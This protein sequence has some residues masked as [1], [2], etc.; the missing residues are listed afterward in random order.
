MTPRTTPALR[1]HR[2]PR[3]MH[4]I[5]RPTAL[6][7]AVVLAGCASPPPP[8][9]PLRLRVIGFND[10]HGNLET[11][12]QTLTLPDPARPGATLRVAAGGAAPMAGLVEA[13]RAGAPHSLVVS[14]GD[15]IGAAPL[16]STLFRHE[17]TIEVMNRI[18]VDVAAVGNHE[19]DAGV[20]ELR[21]MAAGG[22]TPDNPAQ[23]GSACALTPFP[24]A[25][26]TLLAAN[27][28][29]AEGKPL[30][31]PHWVR[32][33]GPVK[34]GV[35]GAVTRWTPGLVVPSGIAGLRFGDEAEAINRS[36]AALKAE[37]VNTLIVTIHE[38]G[39][40]G[41]AQ[42][43]FTHWNDETCPGLR[44]SIVDLAKRITPDVDLIVSGHTHQG[45]RCVVDGRVI[46]QSTSYG[47]GLSVTDLLIDPR[48]GKVDRSAVRSRNLP[49]L[50]ERTDAAQRAALAAA[51][52]APWGAL[53]AQPLS[54]AAVAQQVAGFAAAAAPRTQRVVGQI[55]GSFERGARSGGGAGS[56]AGRLI[57]DA[58]LHATRDPARGGAQLALMNPG[59]VRADLLCNGTP[60]CPVSFG[61]A[62]TVQP[63]GNSLVVMSFS[64]RE[65][66]ALLESQQPPDRKTAYLLQP[67]SNVA[68]RWRPQ[69]PHGQRVDNLRIDGQPV[70]PEA[71]YRLV[72]NSFLAE[73]GDGFPMLTT[74]RDRL[75]GG[76]DLD[77]LIEFLKTNPQPQREPSIELVD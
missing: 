29:Q 40:T 76:Q 26:F 74:G 6:L 21:R 15:M 62:F 42:Q 10:F 3:A 54:S 66:K 61:Q 36:A 53:L 1:P 72:V 56:S 68:Y 55:S 63:F 59:G 27:V 70:Q 46:V 60:P 38:G 18:G 30:F 57:A 47:R 19:F 65:L 9:E 69:A 13:L 20:A 17:T 48:T 71:T 11:T 75:G 12:Q 7:A 44:G 39:E 37:G 5:L 28:T 49:I 67:S 58:Q 16:V 43:P 35:I 2:R 33:Y 4:A 51:E 22:C 32:Q 25:R 14:A 31:A 23:P 24:G 73:G 34:V 77:A 52:P 8:P 41:G 64:G 50:H 45:Y